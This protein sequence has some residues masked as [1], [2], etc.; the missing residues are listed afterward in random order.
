MEHDRKDKKPIASVFL[1]GFSL[2]VLGLSSFYFLLLYLVTGD[3]SHPISQFAL[4]QPWMSLLIVGFGIQ[5]G[6]FLL[7]RR[8][9]YISLS[10]HQ[11]ANLAAGTSTAM[12]GAAMVA[13]CA[14]HLVELLPI[15]GFSAAALFLSEFQQELLMLGVVANLLGITMMFW[16]ITGKAEPRTMFKAVS[17][18]VRRAG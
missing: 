3:P 13:C 10:D 6:L 17:S 1:N 15:L 16:L 7:I 4:L 8:G 9:Y 11:D 14:H 12:S 2:G 5:T 18:Y